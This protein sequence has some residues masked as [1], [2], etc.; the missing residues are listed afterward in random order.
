MRHMGVEF[1]NCLNI[2][3]SPAVS[4]DMKAMPLCCGYIMFMCVNKCYKYVN[5]RHIFCLLLLK[6]KIVFYYTFPWLDFIGLI[7]LLKSIFICI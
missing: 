7:L 3:S 5:I 4:A 6:N 1:G 2:H